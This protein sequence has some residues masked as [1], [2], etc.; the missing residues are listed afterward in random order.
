MDR[1]KIMMYTVTGVFTLMIIITIV[2]GLCVSDSWMEFASIFG[3]ILTPIV[4]VISAFL[5]YESLQQNRT[6]HLNEISL[7]K[8]GG[9]RSLLLS[10]IKGLNEVLAQQVI[11]DAH[12]PT[13]YADTSRKEKIQFQIDDRIREAL[14][15][16][17]VL[18]DKGNVHHHYFLFFDSYIFKDL[19]Y[20]ILSIINLLNSNSIDENE[21][22]ELL[23]LFR[24]LIDGVVL[25]ALLEY[26][27]NRNRHTPTTERD[28]SYVVK[29]ILKGLNRLSCISA[30][31][32]L[33]QY[34][35]SH[36]N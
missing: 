35:K 33:K 21:R 34:C 25:K 8:R 15:K 19:F 11:V 36:H 9:N 16:S 2:L 30:A 1:R 6:Q 14:L 32:C 17:Y 24:G 13:Y 22:S 27:V 3:G 31:S 23:V 10:L 29:E 18:Y 12:T 20:L 4:A 5:F 28:S 7:L 26:C